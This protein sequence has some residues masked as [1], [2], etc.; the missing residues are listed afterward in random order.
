MNFKSF[1]FLIDFAIVAFSI[2][3]VKCSLHQHQLPVLSSG[4]RAYKPLTRQIEKKK[5]R[6]LTIEGVV[7]GLQST[8][9]GLIHIL[10]LHTLYAQVLKTESKHRNSRLKFH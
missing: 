9:D 7:I 5:K 1:V 10:L 2:C 8:S 6:T 3:S 4:L